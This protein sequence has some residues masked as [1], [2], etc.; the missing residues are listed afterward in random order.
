VG[1]K[2]LAKDGGLEFLFGAAENAVSGEI[3]SDMDRR[4]FL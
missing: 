2:K 3:A 4:L 1:I